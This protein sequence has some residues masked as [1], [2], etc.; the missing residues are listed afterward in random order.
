MRRTCMEADYSMME[1]A[2]KSFVCRNNPTFFIG[3]SMVFYNFPPGH[4]ESRSS[5]GGR[6][7][8]KSMQMT[9]FVYS[10]WGLLIKRPPIIVP[11]SCQTSVGPW[12]SGIIVILAVDVFYC[13]CNQSFT[14]IQQNS[15]FFNWYQETTRQ[16][17]LSLL[18]CF[19]PLL[20]PY[21]SRSLHLKSSIHSSMVSS[22]PTE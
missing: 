3:S 8:K 1:T 7:L 17:P 21:K 6:G 2:A 11:L 5:S 20:T 14:A 15:V 19:S 16:T 10:V 18:C 13:F 22:N 9:F 12:N 4:H